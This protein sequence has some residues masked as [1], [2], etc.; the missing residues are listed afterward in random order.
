MPASLRTHLFFSYLAILLLG[1]GVAA[2]LAWR[3]VEKLYIDTQRDNLLAQ[4]SLTAAALQGQPLPIE[5][6]QPYLQTANTLPGIHTRLLSEQGAVLI[7]LPIPNSDITAPPVENNALLSRTELLQRSEIAQALQ[8]QPATAVRSVASAGNRRVLYAAAPV[9]R[10]DGAVSGLVYLAMPLPQTGLPFNWLMELAGAALAAIILASITGTLIAQRVARPMQTIARA[11]AAISDGDLTQHVPLENSISELNGL[12]KAFNRMIESL[13]QSDQ[14]KNTFV[15][16]VTHE[17]RTPLTV[18]KGTIETLEDGGLDDAEGRGPLLDSMQRETDRLI[19]LVN[20][21][22]VLTRADAGTLNLRLQPLDLGEMARSRCEHLAP[23]AAHRQ[24]KLLVAVDE[25]TPPPYVLGDADRISQVLDNLL[26][27]AIRFSPEGS[28]IKVEVRQNGSECECTVHDCGSGIPQ[29][30]L[31]MIFERFYRA[32]ASRNRQTGGAGLGLAIARA[33]VSAQ[34]GRIC[35]ESAEG[36]GT[37]LRF[38]L[39]ASAD[40]LPID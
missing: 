14:A 1:M 20:D 11:A 6:A 32:D 31:P 16:D 25:A 23:L 24:V 9:F 13:R 17:L 40:C 19:R 38:F 34:G 12:G 39:P 10:D 22:L 28:T 2:L 33:L 26:D 5:P 7:G 30:H 35:A 3:S 8:G 37:T 4:A 27:N 18:I 36:E 15:A 21:L 29:K